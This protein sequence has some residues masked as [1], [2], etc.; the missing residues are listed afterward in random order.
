VLRDF[1]MLV[2]VLAAVLSVVAAGAWV[3]D[4]YW[5][6]G[7]GFIALSVGSL[8]GAIRVDDGGRRGYDP[9]MTGG[10]TDE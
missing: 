2:W 8:A 1:L 4:G 5:L 9:Y 10:E 3:E 6:A 7:L